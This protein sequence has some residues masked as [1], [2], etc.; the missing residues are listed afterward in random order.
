MLGK[1][2]AILISSPLAH[3]AFEI[4][5][6]AL[7]VKMR[8]SKKA[9]PLRQTIYII[10]PY[11]TGTLY[12]CKAYN[13]QIAGHQ[14]LQHLSLKKLHRNF[15]A[16]FEQRMNYLDLTLECS[17]FWAGFMDEICQNE[18]ARNLHYICIL[19]SPS[20]WISSVISYWLLCDYLG[21]DSINEHFWK[22]RVGVDL[23]YFSKKSEVE[24]QQIIGRLYEF[25]IE[26]TQKTLKLPNVTYLRIEDLENKFSLIDEMVGEEAIIAGSD[27]NVNKK[28]DFK[29]LNE[30][31]D[32]AYRE[33]VSNFHIS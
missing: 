32:T 1:L 12:L 11:K 8:F 20:S 31:F 13:P 28:K 5:A 26:F 15:D 29:Y 23:R 19:R 22:K 25:Y 16:F 14:P 6:L 10:S 7:E 24:Q 21:Y 2:K 30:E 33:L 27:R 4:N 17:G 9:R 18:I 3:W